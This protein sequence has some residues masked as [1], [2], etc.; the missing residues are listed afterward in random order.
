[1]LAYPEFHCRELW[2]IDLQKSFFE[3]EPF[4][5]FY[6]NSFNEINLIAPFP[7]AELTLYLDWIYL[8]SEIE[9]INC[10]GIWKSAICDYTSSQK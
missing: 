5:R 1:M 3:F 6:F 8:R 2:I 7:W 4:Y 9:F 10:I